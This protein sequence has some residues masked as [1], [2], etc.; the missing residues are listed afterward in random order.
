MN[1]IYFI[2]VNENE[3]PSLK[4]RGF[5][6]RLLGYG[7]TFEKGEY[8]KP[9][10]KERPDFHFNIS[11]TSGAVVI[12]VAEN[13]VGVDIEKPHEVDMRII[14]R[15]TVGEAEYIGTSNQRFLEIWTK[16]EA[17]LKQSGRGLSQKLNSFDVLEQKNAERL[18]TFKIGEYIISVCSEK[19][20]INFKKITV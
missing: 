6:E 19:P 8:G 1:T 3:N 13:E 17:F 12:A 11:H 10:I 20:N 5:L 15:F 14:R 18:E 4:A 9:Y 16:K 7:I 2:T